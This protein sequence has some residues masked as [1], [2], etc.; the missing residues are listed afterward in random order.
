MKLRDRGIV[1]VVS[2]PCP[3]CKAPAGELCRVPGSSLESVTHEQRK[4]KARKA[5]AKLTA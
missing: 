4:R 2:V 3:T 1:N 5:V